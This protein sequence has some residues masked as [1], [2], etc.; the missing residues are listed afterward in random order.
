MSS[1]LVIHFFSKN[2]DLHFKLSQIIFQI[3]FN[4]YPQRVNPWMNE[5]IIYW[6]IFTFI[7]FSDAFTKSL[8]ETLRPNSLI[9]FK[10]GLNISL[11]YFGKKSIFMETDDIN[12]SPS[13]SIV[14]KIWVSFLIFKLFTIRLDYAF[15]YIFY[16]SYLVSL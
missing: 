7:N 2:V 5:A 14:S 6:N 13:E 10:T 4:F 3:K 15:A 11:T 1:L 9:S 12:P 16:W 8:K